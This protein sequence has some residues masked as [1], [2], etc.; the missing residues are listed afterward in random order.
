MTV[1]TLGSLLMFLNSSSVS[2]ALPAISSE[3]GVTTVL[4]DWVLLGYML[5]LTAGVLVFSRLGDLHG[6][7]H[8]YIGGLVVMIVASLLAA[9]SGNIWVLVVL[10]V[11]QGLAA[12]A[13]IP[14]ANAII[15]DAFE[16]DRLALGLSVNIM[17]ASAAMI[18]GP[19]VG[20]WLLELFGWRSIFV[21][22]VPFGLV[23]VGLALAVLRRD[24]RTPQAGERLD[25]RGAVL[26]AVALVV[27]ILALK[28][29]SGAGSALSALGLLA[30]GA[31][32]LAVFVAHVRRVPS[33]LV[34]VA[35]MTDRSRALAYATAFLMSF[36]QSGAMLLVVLYQ[37]IVRG[38]SAVDAGIAVAVLAGA[39]VVTSPLAGWLARTFAPRSVSSAGCAMSA[40]GYVALAVA[41]GGDA[42][43]VL[44]YGGL[45]LVGAGNG[46]FTAPNTAAIMAELPAWRRGI[47]NGVRS[48]M[49]NSA[50]TMGTAV[51]LVLVTVGLSAAGHDTYDVVATDDTVVAGFRVACL[52]LVL[53]AVAAT[54]TSLARGGAWLVQR[55]AAGAPAPSSTPSPL[56][57]PN[58]AVVDPII[59]PD[60]ARA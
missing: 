49:F 3:M 22:N 4:A 28:R 30:L 46:V 55:P 2:V 42:P 52:L 27:L 44:F 9:L 16:S 56:D 24:A 40:L 51:A 38:T 8:L 59:D 20:G 50:Q 7:R 19:V 45:V 57:A 23:A 32:L 13:I 21:V 43:G 29:F 6:R 41:V 15:S 35:V 17:M 26:A 31:V 37:Q 5:S 18:L 54:L 10:R 60:G 33:P 1:T 34:D 48:V 14:N 36:P 53:S 25:V 47:A 12:A 58:D 11:L 39:I